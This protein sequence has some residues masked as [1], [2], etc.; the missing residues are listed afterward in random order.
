MR[1]YNEQIPL[2]VWS[3][4]IVP[5]Y[6]APLDD[7]YYSK[8]LMT[9]LLLNKSMKSIVKYYVEKHAYPEALYDFLLRNHVDL[10]WMFIEANP[11]LE[12]GEIPLVL[13]CKFGETEMVE[14]LLNKKN[15]DPRF[16]NNGPLQVACEGGYYDI[17]NLLLK[18]LR[19]DPSANNNCSIQ[20]AC[21]GGYV[22]VV[23]LLLKDERVDPSANDNRSIECA[24]ENGYIEV[25]KVLLTDIRVTSKK[26]NAIQIAIKNGH[27]EVARVLYKAFISNLSSKVKE[28]ANSLNETLCNMRVAIKDTV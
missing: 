5:Y 2:H 1:E 10:A 4:V 16:D 8:P 18:D 11:I 9:L 6:L 20:Y 3:D 21:E 27:E 25:V 28:C 13:C 12:S 15:S 24:S 17:V 22:D 14:H 26:S 7:I 23:E 19:V